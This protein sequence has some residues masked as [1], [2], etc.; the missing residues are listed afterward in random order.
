MIILTNAPKHIGKASQFQASKSVRD[1]KIF[2]IFW[3]SVLE[4]FLSNLPLDLRKV[5]SNQ[6]ETHANLIQTY[7]AT[8]M[9]SNRNFLLE[10]VFFYLV[11]YL[12]L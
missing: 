9:V 1:R 5:A 6:T 8:C 12:F 11:S 7:K 4:I 3:K 2:G 10:I